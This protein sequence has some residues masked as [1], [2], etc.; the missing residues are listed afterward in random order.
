MTKSK[1]I[2][3]LKH[4]NKWRRGNENLNMI[5]PKTLGKAIDE[6]IRYLEK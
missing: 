5:N 4:H 6:A 3:I 1:I 2:K